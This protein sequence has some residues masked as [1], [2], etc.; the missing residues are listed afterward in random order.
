MIPTA[1]PV[2][3]VAVQRVARRT[4]DPDVQER[5][6]VLWGSFKDHD[7]VS[8]RPAR[9]PRGVCFARALAENLDLLT[10]ERLA[11]AFSPGIDQFEQ[12]VIPVFFHGIGHLLLHF[13][14]WR[15]LTFRVFEDEGVIESDPFGK[16]VRPGIVIV[17]LTR[18]AN[19]NIGS[20]RDSWRH[21]TNPVDERGKFLGC[22]GAVHRFQDPIGTGLQ[23]QMN[24]L[25][26][27]W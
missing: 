8:T 7:F 26:Q 17:G 6:D 19:D 5:A 10:D 16:L 13:R 11:P 22:V 23:W 15:A 12:V 1:L 25:D 24:V 27:L 14:G 21:G 18:I 4:G 3:G 9:Q 2:D 20:D